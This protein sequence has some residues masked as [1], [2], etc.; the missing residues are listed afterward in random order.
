MTV[1][2]AL[3]LIP[4]AGFTGLMATSAIEDF[5]R[6]IIPNGLVV[7]LCLLWPLYVATAPMLTL[8]AAGVAMLCAAA[9][10]VVGALLF[11]R[12]LIGGGDVKL[13]AAASLWA[14]P[15]A[16]LP[17]LV[18]TALLGGLLCLLLVTPVGT[19]IAAL[20]PTLLD[21]SGDPAR[22]ADRVL[23]PYGVA[24]SA[25]ALVVTIPPNFN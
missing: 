1:P 2:V 15:A 8:A 17:L 14:G 18:L 22:G 3:H 19:L 13:L 5:R 16:T 12:G 24:I 7:G 6:L 10:F 23:V 20:R 11:S 25:A 9:V 21:P 4:L